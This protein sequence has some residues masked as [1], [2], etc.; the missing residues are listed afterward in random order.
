MNIDLQAIQ[1]TRIYHW[2]ERAFETEASDLHLIAGYR[3]VLRRH[4]VLT[5]LDEEEVLTAESIGGLLAPV[6]TAEQQ[7][8]IA[9][10][11]NFDFALE[12]PFG[13]ELCRFR[14]NLFLNSGSL[15]GC[16]RVIPT[17]IPDFGWT[18]FPKELAEQIASLQSGLVLFTGVTGAGK[19]T[20]LALIIE[21]L[22]QKGGSRI[23]TIEDPI[24]YR[25]PV[26][27]GSLVSQREVGNDVASFAMAF[28][29]DCGKIP[30]RSWW[31]RFEI[32]RQRAWR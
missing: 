5:A 22:N 32:S 15:G 31:V 10:A 11:K 25:F 19:S 26:R 21:L 14:V 8:T 24:E 18:E 13:S 7:E 17:T 1:S 6:M 20:S 3:P 4:G 16:I 23:L 2:L 27:P 12:L 9:S 30:M 28:V 29:L